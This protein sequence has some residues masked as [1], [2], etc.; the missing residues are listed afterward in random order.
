MTEIN[1][2]EGM[3][4]QIIDPYTVQIGDTSKFSQ[5]TKNGFLESYKTPVL[6]NF[7]SYDESLI[8]PV[9][10]KEHMLMMSDMCDFFMNQQLHFA[11][12]AVR[13]FQSQHNGELPELNNQE[14]ADEI[15]KIAT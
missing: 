3:P 5:Y 8:S 2:V 15:L 11:F 12:R 6:H 4:V 9:G 14:H 1:D 10:D 7:K 13:I